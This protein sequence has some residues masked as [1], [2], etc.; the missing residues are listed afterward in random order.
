MS[1]LSPISRTQPQIAQ[2]ELKFAGP[3]V[4]GSIV[5][6]VSDLLSLTNNYSHKL[7]WVKEHSCNY[8]LDNGDGSNLSNW[9]KSSARVVIS[10]YD[11]AATYLAGDCVYQ[12]GKI[13]AAKINVPINHSPMDYENYWQVISGETETYRYLF[14][15]ASSIII[16]TE[17]RNPKFEI[18]LGE[19][20]YDIN[21]TIVFNEET[22]LAELSNK[23]IVEA[24]VLQR[25]DLPLNNGVAYEIRFYEDS[26]LS[27]QV[28][29]CINVK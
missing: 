18:I 29:G 21:G 10:I 12:T 4:K 25:E 1:E 9:K 11:S 6:L 13:Y 17:I 2:L 3:L 14:T 5:E 24:F 19:F 27:P 7:V 28:S 22:G 8:Y 16:Y 23:E 26:V 20:V 15:N